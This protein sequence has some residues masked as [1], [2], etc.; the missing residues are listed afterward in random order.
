MF[1]DGIHAALILSEAFTIAVA[2]WLGL[3]AA[4]WRNE[5]DDAK[6]QSAIN[7]QLLGQLQ[8]QQQRRAAE[9][10]RIINEGPPAPA[11]KLFAHDLGG[12]A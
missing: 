9:A 2:V 6:R 3:M 5:A 8:R 7:A 11:A 1:A 12:E 4:R 10:P